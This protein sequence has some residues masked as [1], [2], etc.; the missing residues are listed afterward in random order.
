VVEERRGGVKT[1]FSLPDYAEGTLGKR[2]AKRSLHVRTGNNPVG[3]ANPPGGG[4]EKSGGISTR[5]QGEATEGGVLGE[6]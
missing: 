5:S 1:Y 3:W 4:E 2:G 6:K